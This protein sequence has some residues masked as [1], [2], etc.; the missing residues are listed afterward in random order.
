M[1]VLREKKTLALILLA[2]LFIGISLV[3]FVLQRSTDDRSR[4]TAATTLSFL[5][6][7][8]AGAPIQ[9]IPGEVVSLDVMINPGINLVSQIRLFIT[10]DSTKLGIPTDGIFFTPNSTA[11]PTLN[12]SPT[13]VSS[14]KIGVSLSTGTDPSKLVTTTTKVGTLKLRTLAATVTGTPTI[15]RFDTNTLVLS[16]GSESQAT[17]NVL[18]STSPAYVAI[19]GPTPT[20]SPTLVPTATPTRTP[21]PT[22]TP[23]PTPTTIPTATPTRVPTA[24][25][26][27]LPTATPTRTPTPTP[28]AT[29]TPSPTPRGTALQVKVV[30]HGIGSGGDNRTPNVS[31]TSNKNPIHNDRPFILELIKTDNTKLTGFTGRILY[32]ETDGTFDG[33]VDG[34]FSIPAGIYSY[35]VIVNGLLSRTI[36]TF[37]NINIGQINILPPVTLV[38]GD[39]DSDNKLSILD[40]NIIAQCYNPSR[41]ATDCTL[42]QYADLNDDGIID[43]LDYNLWLRELS[44]Q[45]GE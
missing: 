44:V 1:L 3:I 34:G 33:S 14:G 23:T 31:E 5:P 7:S 43:I 10:Y 9:K 18:S 4:A 21:T 38:T 11:F 8:S 27:S 13:I 25:P 22:F 17:E 32:N 19:I 35:R 30:L 6:S 20:P 28:S 41:P 24:T 45:P 12:Q 15:I 2:V 29:P 40:Y 36:Q 26:T 39:V 16:A 42:S 37:Q